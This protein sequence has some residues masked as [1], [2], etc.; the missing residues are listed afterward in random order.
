MLDRFSFARGVFQAVRFTDTKWKD[1]TWSLLFCKEI[2]LTCCYLQLKFD[3]YEHTCQPQVLREIM[4]RKT[5]HQVNF[6]RDFLEIHW[7]IELKVFSIIAPRQTK[8]YFFPGRQKT[9]DV[10]NI[11]RRGFSTQFKS[12]SD[13][14]EKNSEN[15]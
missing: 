7:L 10:W 12:N 4:Q 8:K 14:S 5:L 6:H 9:K 15:T 3:N 2:P 1:N 13:L 11:H